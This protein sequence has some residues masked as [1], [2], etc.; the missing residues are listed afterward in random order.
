MWEYKEVKAGVFQVGFYDSTR[1][2]FDSEHFA[3]K[4]ALD[5]IAYLNEGE[6]EPGNGKTGLVRNN[7]ALRTKDIGPDLRPPAEEELDNIEM[8]DW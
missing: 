4:E 7:N 5:R 8:I 1:W 6:P 2:L 3:E